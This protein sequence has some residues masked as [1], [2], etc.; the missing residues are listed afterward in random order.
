MGKFGVNGTN[1]L[2]FVLTRIGITCPIL[3]VA[4]FFLKREK[5]DFKKDFLRLFICGFLLFFEGFAYII[6]LAKSTAKIATIWQSMI[7]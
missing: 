6:G 5:L 2:L 3:C 1:P 7:V 4:G